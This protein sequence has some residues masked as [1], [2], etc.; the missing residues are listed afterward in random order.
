MGGGARALEFLASTSCNMALSRLSSATSF[1]SLSFSSCSC[2]QLPD[3]IDL[4][5]YKLLLPSIEGLLGDPHLTA[6]LHHWHAL[7]LLQNGYN[8]FH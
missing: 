3:L 5:P 4:Q 8:L 6:H 1:L 7:G 2:F